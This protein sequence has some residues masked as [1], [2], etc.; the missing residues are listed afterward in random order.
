MPWRIVEPMDKKIR[1]IGD[2]LSKVFNFSEPCD[3]YGIK[4]LHE[5]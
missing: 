1:F 4:R 5:T 3:R 2:Y